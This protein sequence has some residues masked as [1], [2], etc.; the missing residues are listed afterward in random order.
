MHAERLEYEVEHELRALLE[1]ARAPERRP[2][3]EAPLGVREAALELPDLE[4]ADGRLEAAK[5]HGKT[6]VRADLALAVRPRDESLEAFDAR[7]RRRDEARD[8]FGRQQRE[9]RLRVR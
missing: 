8:F 4:D 9:Q 6:D 2:D 5:R 1:H 7:R 3:R